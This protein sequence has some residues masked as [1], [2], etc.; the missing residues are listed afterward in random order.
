MKK[1]TLTIEGKEVVLNFAPNWFF[2]LYKQDSGHDLVKDPYLV[3]VDIDSIELFKYLQSMIWAA[4]EA[5]CKVERKPLEIKREDVEYFVMGG[6]IETSELAYMVTAAYYGVSVD[7]LK[8]KA[9]PVEEE[10]KNL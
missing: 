8:K 10:K 7:E 4:Y 2:E 5:N 1:L 6:V 9:Q 3:D